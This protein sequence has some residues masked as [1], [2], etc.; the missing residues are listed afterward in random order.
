M[1][2]ND[3]IWNDEEVAASFGDRLKI[4]GLDP[5]IRND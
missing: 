5:L 3:G 4:I 1:Y 2:V